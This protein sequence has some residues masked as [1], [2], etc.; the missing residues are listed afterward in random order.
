M[1]LVGTWSD[2]SLN[3]ASHLRSFI[4]QGSF[5]VSTVQGTSG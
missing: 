2:L 4:F 1:P 3:D 5:E